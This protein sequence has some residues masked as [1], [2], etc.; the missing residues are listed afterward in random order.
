M[1]H[2]LSPYILFKFLHQTPISKVE[3]L[4][5]LN[6]LLT[7]TSHRISVPAL[8]LR[9]PSRRISLL[10]MRSGFENTISLFLCFSHHRPMCLPCAWIVGWA[11]FRLSRWI[12]AAI[13][14]AQLERGQANNS[15]YCSDSSAQ[16]DSCIR[17]EPAL[18]GRQWVEPLFFIADN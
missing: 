1:K 18:L 14:A 10:K 17:F 2:C 9:T 5:C 4:L 3:F 8:G 13:V 7:R 6:R 11:T 15:L 16:W 12:S